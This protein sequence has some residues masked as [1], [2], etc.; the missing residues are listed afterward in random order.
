MTWLPI[1]GVA[2]AVGAPA[3]KDPPRK[4][5]PPGLVGAWACT[6]IVA[7]GR[8]LTESVKARIVLEFTSDGKLRT[9]KGGRPESEGSYTADATRD[10]AAVD[11]TVEAEGPVIRAIYEAGKETLTL[12]FEDEADGKR[13]VAF[14]GTGAARMLVTFR[15]VPDKK[16]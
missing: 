1:L 9:T 14:S 10:P 13:P 5:D 3:A 2:L 8:P 7:D 16:E 4:A 11:F 15:R 12:C 6:G